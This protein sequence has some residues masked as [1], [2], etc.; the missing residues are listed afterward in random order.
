MNTR[1]CTGLVGTL[2][3]EKALFTGTVTVDGSHMDRIHCR[4]RVLDYGGQV[5]P[6]RS[7]TVTL[8]VYG[9]FGARSLTDPMREY[10]QKLVFAEQMMSHGGPHIHVIDSVGFEAL[11]HGLP[12]RCHRLR[13]CKGVVRAEAVI[14]APARRPS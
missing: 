3:G 7:R 5:A 9:D 10:S 6:D 4:Q 12:A 13:E 11:L 2:R 14:A 8:L 1:E